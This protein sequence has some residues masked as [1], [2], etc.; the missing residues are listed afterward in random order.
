V[1][2]INGKIVVE[3]GVLVSVDVNAIVSHHDR[4]AKTMLERVGLL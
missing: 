1:S 3:R 4:I 2:V